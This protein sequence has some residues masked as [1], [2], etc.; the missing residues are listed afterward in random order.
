MRITFV[1]MVAMFLATILH[2]PLSLYIVYELDMGIR[3][4]PLAISIKDCIC[5]FSVL[6]YCNCST[7]ISHCL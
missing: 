7:Q 4:F 1:P 2:I 3:G 5:L 6:V